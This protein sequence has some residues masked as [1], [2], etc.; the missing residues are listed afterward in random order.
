M[1]PDLGQKQKSQLKEAQEIKVFQLYDWNP[2]QFLKITPA[3][4]D[5]PSG[6]QKAKTTTKLRKYQMSELNEAW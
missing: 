3:P 5:S 6:H 4:N 2:K 1:T